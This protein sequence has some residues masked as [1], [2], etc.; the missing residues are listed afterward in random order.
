VK[1]IL[2]VPI[3]IYEPL[4]IRI[5]S[6]SLLV[7]CGGLLNEVH[8]SSESNPTPLSVFQFPTTDFTRVRMLTAFKS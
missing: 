3:Q 8:F 2:L 1:E 6:R 7:L 5:E 4:A